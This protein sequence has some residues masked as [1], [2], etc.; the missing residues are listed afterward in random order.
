VKI[1]KMKIATSKRR[2]P[3]F[4]NPAL[5]SMMISTLKRLYKIYTNLV[6]FAEMVNVGSVLIVLCKSHGQA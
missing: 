4:F 2:K 5:F 3:L 6:T 1:V